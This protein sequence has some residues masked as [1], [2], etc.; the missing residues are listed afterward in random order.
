MGNGNNSDIHEMLKALGNGDFN[1][2][3]DP[4]PD[5]QPVASW[6]ASLNRLAEQLSRREERASRML[7]ESERSYREIFN[8]ATDMIFVQDAKTGEFLDFNSETLRATGYSEEEFKEGGVALFSPAAPEYSMERAMDYVTKASQGKPQLF[9]WAFVDKGGVLHP[10]EVHLKLATIDGKQCLLGITRDI[11]ERKQA[12]A[13]KK[14]LEQKV[15]QV[16]KLESLGLLAGGIA[17]DFNNILMGVMGHANLARVHC[18][19]TSQTARH[20]QKVETA[21]R[22]AAELIQQ[23]LLFA[24]GQPLA[25]VAVDLGQEIEEM[26]QLLSA[27]VSKKA[28]LSLELAPGLRPVAGTPNAVRQIALKLITNASEALSEDGGTVTVRI[29]ASQAPA[30][31]TVSSHMN[32]LEQG[33]M[34]NVLEVE[35]NGSGMDAETLARAFDP[36]VSSKA[37][38]RGLGLATVL[39]IVRSH[40]GAVDVDS[41]VGR[42]TV[43]RVLLPLSESHPSRQIEQEVAAPERGTV[44]GTVL[45]VDDEEIVRDTTRTALEDHGL[46]V[47]TARNGRECLQ[48]YRLHADSIDAI[49]LDVSMPLLSGPEALD[50][51]RKSGA[52]VPVILSSGY[53]EQQIRKDVPK[54][55]RPDAFLAK[56]YIPAQLLDTLQRVLKK[57]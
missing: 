55:A 38:G 23:M 13:E 18:G 20:I 8:A 50:A 14:E 3:L 46:K 39:G 16:Q 42:G 47:I 15:L 40:R 22:R 56:P 51:L 25:S 48:L 9:E 27:A 26:G 24:G 17:H 2:R 10:T 19:A 28:H 41:E 21:A 37:F 33:V 1:H 6:R 30:K 44:S 49:V 45:V 43:F 34:H 52:T 36:F 4:R 57:R 32:W 31:K 11:S 35:D 29:K 54:S 5:D 12:E 53:M 7:S